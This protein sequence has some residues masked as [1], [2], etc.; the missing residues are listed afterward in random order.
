METRFEITVAGAERG[1]R[2]ENF[3]FDRFGGLSRMYLRDVVKG[4][5]CE[6]NGRVE[7]AGFRLRTNDFVEVYLD[8]SRESAMTPQKMA[9]NSL[10]EDDHIVVV[11]KP[12]GLLAHPTHREKS[13]TLLNGLAFYLNRNILGRAA[14]KGLNGC[15]HGREIAGASGSDRLAPALIRP[16]LVHRLDRE[17]SGLMVVARNGAAHRILARQFQRKLVIK[18]YL[19]MVSGTVAVENGEIHAPIGRLANEKRWAV[20]EG[21][22]DATTHFRVVRRFDGFTL[23][24]LEPITGRTNQL[25]IHCAHIGHPIV[26]DFHRGG[27]RFERLCLHACYLRFR[28]PSSNSVVEFESR[29]TPEAFRNGPQ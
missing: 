12:S 9:I 14:D 21:G 26:G 29:I 13:G 7:N 15:S 28:H 4:E 5:R 23:I 3:L 1:K 2:L 19:A 8:I 22:K 6:V 27:G 16:G 25:R 24:E 18:R 10:Y 17:T 11:D 20:K